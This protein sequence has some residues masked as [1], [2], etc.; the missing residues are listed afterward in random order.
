[1]NFGDKLRQIRIKNGM[2]MKDVALILGLSV[3]YISDIERGNRNPLSDDRIKALG[4]S[5]DEIKELI[6]ARG[7][8]I[9]STNVSEIGKEAGFLLMLNWDSLSDIKHKEIIKVLNIGAGK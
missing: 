3:A 5:N 6:I 2:K 9:L 7:D 4:F 1:M 8:F